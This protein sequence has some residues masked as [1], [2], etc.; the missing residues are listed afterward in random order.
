MHIRG[1]IDDAVAPGRVLPRTRR[2]WLIVTLVLILALGLRL[3][4]VYESSDWY[5]PRTDA[6][7]FDVM[8]SSLAR[9]DGFGY[10]IVPP[11]TKEQKEPTAF[12]AP[13]FPLVL[14]SVYV[15]FGEHSYGAGRV[16]NAGL[17]T[18]VVVALG[19]V[20]SQ[21]WSRRLA[22]VAMA[23]AAVH[24]A[25][26]VVGSSLLLEPLLVS[27]ML[28]ALV[29]ALQH[30]RRPRGRRWAVLSGL[31]LG[32]AIL[33]RET[34]LFAVLPVTYLVWQ[35]ER[36]RLGATVRRPGPA[37]WAP[38]ILL[39]TT[40]V[41]VM[42]WTIRNF[43][44]LDDFVPVSTSS[45]IGLAGTYN[46][47]SMENESM[48]G[49]WR[50]PWEDPGMLAVMHALDDPTEAEADRA[51][52]DASLDLVREHPRYLMT[53]IVYNTQR[54]F[55]LDGGEFARLNAP[56]L[57]WSVRLLNMGILG[58][59]VLY[60]LAALG[61]ILCRSTHARV[62]RAVWLIPLTTLPFLVIALPANIRYR[63]WLEPFLVL[64]ATP[65][66]AAVAERLLRAVR[67]E[68]ADPPVVADAERV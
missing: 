15:V 26:I 52:R 33:T 36:A 5:E 22:L 31:L 61:A 45:G 28:F 65:L 30:R 8:A 37:L 25:L 24:P 48:P 58:S 50:P 54:L 18:V 3:G 41:V 13:L 17:G 68:A 23:I 46:R 63:Y 9:G 59:Y 14:A 1:A 66:V 4:A 35:G 20:A 12:R 56:F 40:V 21:L 42:P 10:A 32:L 43:V 47:T 51:L 6:L 16:L 67:P 19:I 38:A 7:H 49:A 2:G 44:V 64:L 60:L 39:L 53:A 11:N 55:D 34:A 62:P 29:C 27:L 57:P